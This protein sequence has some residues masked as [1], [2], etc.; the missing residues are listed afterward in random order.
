MIRKLSENLPVVKRKRT[1]PPFF[2]T[3]YPKILGKGLRIN[4]FYGKEDKI[5]IE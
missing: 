5:K 2:S 3:G 4:K 1:R